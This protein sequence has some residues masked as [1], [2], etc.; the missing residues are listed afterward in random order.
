MP[1]GTAGRNRRALRRDMRHGARRARLGAKRHGTAK[2]DEDETAWRGEAARQDERAWPDQIVL[3]EAAACARR[4]GGGDR[5]PVVPGPRIPS[6]AE[7]G[8]GASAGGV[9]GGGGTADPE[10]PAVVLTELRAL[11]EPLLTTGPMPVL[12]S[13]PDDF[14]AEDLLGEEESW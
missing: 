13:E 14:M 5:Q 6:A 2:R 9:T 11:L 12:D 10:R 4:S 8:D 1:G 3:R 7:T